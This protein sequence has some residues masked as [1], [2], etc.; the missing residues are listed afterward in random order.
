M[1]TASL[2]FSIASPGTWL[3]SQSAVSQTQNGRGFIAESHPTWSALMSAFLIWLSMTSRG[4]ITRSRFSI[5][6]ERLRANAAGCETLFLFPRRTWEFD[7][8]WRHHLHLIDRLEHGVKATRNIPPMESA[9]ICKQI[10]TSKPTLPVSMKNDQTAD[11]CIDKHR[12]FPSWIG[13]WASILKFPRHRRLS[14]DEALLIT[15]HYKFQAHSSPNAR[16]F[17]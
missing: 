15:V 8:P 14:A 5:I 10:S 3:K 4:V 16:Y 11:K 13:R 9:K 1:Q 6:S 17:K 12:S 7:S 2:N